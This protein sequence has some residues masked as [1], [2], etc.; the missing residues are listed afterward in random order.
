[1]LQREYGFILCTE[2]AEHFHRPGKSSPGW[3]G[4]LAPAVL[5]LIT[6]LL[7]MSPVFPV[8]IRERP[9]MSFFTG[10]NSPVFAARFGWERCVGSGSGAFFE[11]EGR[12][13]AGPG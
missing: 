1:M 11:G 3:T 12:R 5:G 13:A 8:G 9:T 2:A 4:L 7:A 10:N 6:R